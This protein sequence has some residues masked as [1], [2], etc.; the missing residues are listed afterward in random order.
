MP[1]L[2]QCTNCQRKLRV[3]DHLLGKTVKCP[4]CH[5]KFLAQVAEET[6][7]PQA[8]QPP[9]PS[10]AQDAAA[11]SPIEEMLRTPVIPPMIPAMAPD[12]SGQ[13]LDVTEPASAPS[14]APSGMPRSDEQITAVPA[15]GP[16]PPIM[17]VPSA[18]PVPTPVPSPQGPFETPVLHVLA[19]LGAIVLLAAIAGCGCGW[20]VGA[21]VENA[22]ATAAS[23]AP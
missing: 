18:R 20:W 11:P 13:A 15:A 10:L 21:A 22:A 3:Q 1:I 5:I 6:A 17:P 2:I 7:A 19:V 9:E 14:A 16:A 8:A 12:P 4:N 23:N